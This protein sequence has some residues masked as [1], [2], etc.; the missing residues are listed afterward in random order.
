VT[1][2]LPQRGYG[3]G[4]CFSA[5]APAPLFASTPQTRWS[6]PDAPRNSY[7]VQRAH[8][9]GPAGYAASPAGSSHVTQP[10]RGGRGGD[11]V[12][13]YRF[14]PAAVVTAVGGSE[15]GCGPALC[16]LRGLPPVLMAQRSQPIHI[17]SPV[18]ACGINRCRRLKFPTG[19]VVSRL[20]ESVVRV[21]SQAPSINVN[22]D[23]KSFV[24]SAFERAQFELA[25]VNHMQ[26]AS[27]HNSTGQASLPSSRFSQQRGS[28]YH[29]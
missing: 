9:R 1:Q 6:R 15:G 28:F 8:G 24:P 19:H 23:V 16:A 29:P 26:A 18:P 14:P 10:T 7:T 4:T 3:A 2:A 13:R 20:R 5:P 22:Q 12:L 17:S 27:C 11:V 25:Q 21:E